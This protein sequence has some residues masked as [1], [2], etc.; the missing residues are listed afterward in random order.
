MEWCDKDPGNAG[1]PKNLEEARNGY[2]PGAFR[3]NQLCEHLD[4]YFVRLL[5]SSD[6]HNWKKLD[7][8]VESH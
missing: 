4:F 1:S 6:P 5:W 2:F 3:K 8:I 7:G